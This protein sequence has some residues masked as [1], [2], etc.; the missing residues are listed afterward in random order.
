M[1]LAGLTFAALLASPGC[2]VPQPPGP[3]PWPRRVDGAVEGGN[4]QA[5]LSPAEPQVPQA[6]AEE[7]A[8]APER[9]GEVEVLE[10]QASA[11]EAQASSHESQVAAQPQADPAPSAPPDLPEASEMVASPEVAAQPAAPDEAAPPGDVS[12]SE[13][14]SSDL[15]PTPPEILEQV[16]IY[17]AALS[18]RDWKAAAECFWTAGTI[19]RV[20][21]PDEGLPPEVIV[22]PAGQY[23]ERLSIGQEGPPEGLKGSLDGRQ[24]PILSAGNVAQVWCRYVARLEGPEE[25]MRWQ[26]YDAVTLVLHQK[27]WKIASVIQGLPLERP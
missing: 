18:A 10:A 5:A 6:S 17:Y 8:G 25:V 27:V 26:R 7:A 11:Q 20:A 9:V 24:P 14:L 19:T 1:G 4:E 12:S 22:L 21:S 16:R 23:F 13:G 15:P 2:L 3:E